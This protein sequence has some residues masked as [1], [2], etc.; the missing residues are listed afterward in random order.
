[1]RLL[2]IIN[3]MEVGGAETFLESLSYSLDPSIDVQIISLSG[4]GRIASR[5]K[6]RGYQVHELNFD[7]TFIFIDRIFELF[8]LIKKIKPDVVH[9]WMYH[10]NLL[11]GFA[12]KILGIKKIIWSLHAFNI[13]KGMLKLRT[14]FLIHVLA[15]FS[16]YIPHKII[17]C[18]QSSLL[19]HRNLFYDK[20]KL[21][22]IPNGV[23]SKNFFIQKIL[24]QIFVQ[25]LDLQTGK[26]S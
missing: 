21:I 18:S 6:G 23:N 19:I 25:N 1:M 26:Y 3:S 22:F 4:S 17:C 13:K 5:M 14:R 20:K 12:A 16:H 8:F 24:G 7:K 10:S 2:M 9:T 11:G 15:L